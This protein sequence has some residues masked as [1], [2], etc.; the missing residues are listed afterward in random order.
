MK[1]PQY[2]CR[3]IGAHTNK[4]SYFFFSRCDRALPAMLF[5]RLLER[6]S[7]KASDACFATF[8]EVTFFAIHNYLVWQFGMNLPPSLACSILGWHNLALYYNQPHVM[9]LIMIHD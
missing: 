7:R 9:F 6:P 3:H 1:K 2:E 5:V 8:V 4:E